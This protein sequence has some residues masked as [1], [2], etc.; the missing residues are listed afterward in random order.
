M[1]VGR[2]ATCLL[3]AVALT[4]CGGSGDEPIDE[5]V[6]PT[7]AP[8]A[9]VDTPQTTLGAEVDFGEDGAATEFL[10]ALFLPRSSVTDT[11]VDCINDEL[12]K[13]YPDGLPAVESGN[14]DEAL[15][16][17]VEACGLIPGG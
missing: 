16:S 10:E 8:Q 15:G 7:E 12:A 14:R 11:Q 3:V 13:S 1:T 5:P 17:I 2:I 9:T 4:A 6:V